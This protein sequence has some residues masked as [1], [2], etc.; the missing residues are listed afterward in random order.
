MKLK[1]A[2]REVL[3]EGSPYAR[4]AWVEIKILREHDG[5]TRVALRT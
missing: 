2:A 3:V 5:M 1:A 4:R